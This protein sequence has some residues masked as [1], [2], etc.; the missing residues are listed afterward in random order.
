MESTTVLQQPA[1]FFTPPSQRQPGWLS[2]EDEVIFVILDKQGLPK[3]RT[4]HICSWPGSHGAGFEVDNVSKTIVW[5]DQVLNDLS[6]NADDAYEKL[7]NVDDSCLIKRDEIE[8]LFYLRLER[9]VRKNGTVRLDGDL[10]EVPLSLRA[11]KNHSSTS[12]EAA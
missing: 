5:C 8:P 7:F 6:D 1:L 9:T 12:S 3:I 4:G 2:Y 10:Y 11:L